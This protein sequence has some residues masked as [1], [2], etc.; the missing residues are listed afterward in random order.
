MELLGCLIEPQYVNDLNYD[1]NGF[2]TGSQQVF[3]NDTHSLV[4]FY[5]SLLEN[6][7]NYY[8]YNITIQE[9]WSYASSVAYGTVEIFVDNNK[10][11]KVIVNDIENGT[12]KDKYNDCFDINPNKYLHLIYNNK[13]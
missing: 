10:I 5:Y 9:E 11:N 3:F 8:K 4:S 1:S 2:L 13:N 6:N 12:L 7:D